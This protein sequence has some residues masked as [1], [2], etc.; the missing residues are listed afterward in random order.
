MNAVC[1]M[2]NFPYLSLYELPDVAAEVAAQLLPMA[3][4]PENFLTNSQTMS[5]LL[6]KAGMSSCLVSTG[7]LPDPGCG[8]HRHG[9]GEQVLQL[10]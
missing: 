7:S 1:V 8:Q 5:H 3:I 10:S 2:T 4:L 9:C 6:F